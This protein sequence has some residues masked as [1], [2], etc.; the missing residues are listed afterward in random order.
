M[1]P[2]MALVSQVCP[3]LHLC[4]DFYSHGD[5]STW[6]IL[7]AVIQISFRRIRISLMRQGG[8]LLH[9]LGHLQQGHETGLHYG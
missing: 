6:K 8:R 5:H 2:K 3:C 7:T 1:T 4:F 9:L